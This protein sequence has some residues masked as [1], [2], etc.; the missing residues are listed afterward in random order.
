[1]RF[2]HLARQ[3]AVV[4][5]L[6]VHRHPGVVLDVVLRGALRLEVGEL[7]EVVLEAVGVAAIPARPERRLG[8]GHAARQRHLLI[9][10]GRARHHVR[11]MIDVLHE[12]VSSLQRS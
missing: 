6:R 9:V 10:V 2:E 7:P 1:M 3:L 5:L 8:D 12:R 11:V 4:G